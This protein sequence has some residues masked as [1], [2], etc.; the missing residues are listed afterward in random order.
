MSLPD[1]NITVQDGALGIVPEDT[2]NIILHVGVASSGT[3]LEI[4][5]LTTQQ[6]IVDTFGRGPLVD[7]MALDLATA[8]GPVLGARIASTTAGACG[9]VDQTGTGVA[10][11]V[12][13]GAANDAYDVQ[14]E[15]TKGGPNLAANTGAFKY[16][17]DGGNS[18]SDEIAI[19]TGGIYVIPDTG[20][21]I[22]WTDGVGTDFVVGDTY[23]FTSTAPSYALSDLQTALTTILGDPRDW[24]CLHVVGAAATVAAAAAMAA[25]LDTIMVEQ[26]TNFR[27][28]FAV[29]EAPHDTD[30]T[31]ITA[32]AST[33][34]KRVMAVADTAQ[35][36]SPITG[37]VRSRPAAWPVV[38]RI[39]AVPIHEDLGRVR[40]GGIVGVTELD[41][42][43]QLTPG[44]DAAR[45][46]TLR[47]IIGLPGFWVTSGRM[48]A[49]AGSDFT[50]VQNRRVM[51]RACAIARSELLEYLNDSV[52]LDPTTGLILEREAR[53]IEAVVNAALTNELVNAGHAS[54]A[55]VL[56]DRNHDINSDAT[57]PV[58]IQV[59]PRGYMRTISVSIG[60]V[61]PA[62]QPKS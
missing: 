38:A 43:E 7:A 1:V 49:P 19:P 48:L 41:R 39:A 40:T 36:L 61:N 27:Y 9:A 56:I 31:V 42:D 32:F 8:G 34:S 10:T 60:F 24:A 11:L 13:S 52:L 6:Q 22:T 28:A 12:A 29:I 16:S 17:L 18:W 30:A 44:L 15:I 47:T 37:L 33:S 50:Y 23:D 14:V 26:E 58:T 59:E 45:L 21:T 51:D 35:Q 4:E 53:A 25:A 2:S 20:I 62:L 46:T 54:S 55:T 3:D 5:S 57:M